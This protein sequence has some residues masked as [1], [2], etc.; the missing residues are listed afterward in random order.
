ML[1]KRPKQAQDEFWVATASLPSS[2]GHPFYERLDALLEEHGFD[3]FVEQLC[4]RFYSDGTGRPGTAPG[5]Y[6]RMLIVGYFE[7]I[8]SE[9]GIAWRCADSL[10]LRSFLGIPLDGRVPDHSVVSRTRRK[11]DVETHEEVFL[12]VMKVLGKHGCLDG[13]TVGIDG[14]TQEA[15]AAL[16]SIVRRDTGEDYDEFL[17]RLAQESGIET[18]TRADLVKI[19][20]KRKNK[21]SND[22]WEHPHDPDARITKMKDGSTHL[23]HKVEH[24]IDMGGEGAVLAVTVQDASLGDTATMAQTI[25]TA[26]ALLVKARE[27]PATGTDPDEQPIKEIV[28][29]KGY[30]SNDTL[31]WL[32]ECGYRTYVSEP[33]RGRRN[34]KGKEAERD[35]VYANRRRIKGERGKALLRKRGELVERPFEHYLDRGGMRRAHLRHDENILKRLLIHVGG[36]NLGIVMR[37]LFG[38]GTPRG[39]KALGSGARAAFARLLGLVRS[40]FGFLWHFRGHWGRIATFRCSATRLVSPAS[41]LS[42]A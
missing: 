11:V 20:R 32:D 9:R 27:R 34:W 38:C 15:N 17:T 35:A 1:G 40:V 5:V 36:F 28:Q 25:M 14:T 21:G 10:A 12:W 8:D 30:H 22:D 31:L 3:Q 2:P 33:D 19:D 13:K 39:W 23:A 16:R 26:E 42:A 4:A 29:D 18:P 37:K 7:R 41:R 24:A 6:F